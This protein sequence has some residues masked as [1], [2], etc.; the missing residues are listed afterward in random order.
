MIN[1]IDTHAH[2]YSSEFADDIDA[3]ISSARQ[4]GVYRIYMPNIDGQSIEQMLAMEQAYQGY[5]FPMMG[6]H[7]CYVKDDFRAQ[8]DLIETWLLKRTFS[9]V[10]EIGIDLYWDKTFIE[11]QITAFET[12]INWA[13]SLRLPV[14]IHCRD[15]V[16]ISIDIVNKH[17]NGYL[18]GV[19]HCFSGTPEQAR[20]IIDMGFLLG[21]GGVAT[22]KNGG[23]DMLLPDIDLRHLV[24]ETDSPY[25]APVP[26]RGKRNQPAYLADIAA[27]VASV[28]A[29]SHE[30]VANRT[31]EN[32]M[33]LFGHGR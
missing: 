12:Q 10:G 15:S 21:I 18:R 5:C 11:Q 29:C 2:L 7:P 3:V 16:E 33:N 1:L 9:A 6:L 30:E 19:F 23:L 17:Q 22:F 32:A 26:Y 25:L 27:R 24:L 14:A 8:L 20:Q 28:K 4:A 31:T 13:R